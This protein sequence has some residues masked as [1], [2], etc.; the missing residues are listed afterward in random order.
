MTLKPLLNAKQTAELLA[1]HPETLYS[2][3]HEIGFIRVGRAVKFHP[4]DVLSYLE[5][6]SSK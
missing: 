6:R 5:R 2:I 4:D 3:K 1:I